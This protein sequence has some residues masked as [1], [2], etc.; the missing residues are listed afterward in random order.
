MPRKERKTRGGETSIESHR[1]AVTS[2]VEAIVSNLEYTVVPHEETKELARFLSSVS[3]WHEELDPSEAYFWLSGFIGALVR[4]WSSEEYA[5]RPL[6]D[7][8]RSFVLTAVVDEILRVPREYEVYF[9]LPSQSSL[10]AEVHISPTVS[11]FTYEASNA[12]PTPARASSEPVGL[13]GLFSRRLANGK[14]YLRLKVAGL[15]AHSQSS[16]AASAAIGAVKRI[17][18]LSSLFGSGLLPGKTFLQPPSE[19]M[20]CDAALG[21]FHHLDAAP[22][23]LTALGAVQLQSRRQNGLLAEFAN[24]PSSP[25]DDLRRFKILLGDGTANA[26]QEKIRTALEWAF[27][28]N[29]SSNDTRALIEA[30]IAIEALIGE[31]S[32]ERGLTD[33]L[34]DRCAFALAKTATERQLIMGDFRDIYR[35]RSQLVHGR[36]PRLKR[37][38]RALLRRAQ[39]LLGRLLTHEIQLLGY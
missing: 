14:T 26:E 15:F 1:A 18:M 7:Q 32:T 25:A 4:S 33:R 39:E 31:D 30:C 13:A 21:T 22:E 12:Q 6:N 3:P 11:I 37:T 19:A 23:V 17:L 24:S 36:T 38:Q 5:N 10:E 28:S 20:V 2:K 9:T 29:N 8:G 35:L 34:V 27:D 16:P